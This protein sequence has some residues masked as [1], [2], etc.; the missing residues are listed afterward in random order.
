MTEQDTGYRRRAEDFKLHPED[1]DEIYPVAERRLSR[2]RRRAPGKSFL[3]KFR[4][5]I[6]GLSLVGAAAPL[7]QSGATQDTQPGPQQANAAAPTEAE[8]A[9]LAMAQ[10]KQVDVEDQLAEKVAAEHHEV[11]TASIVGTAVKKFDIDEKLAQDIYEIAQ[12]EGIEPKLAYG[13]VK[14]ESSFRNEAK[15]HVGALGLTQVM[16][17]TAKWLVPGTKP[18]DLHDQR[19]NLRLGFKYLN[20]MI[21][22]YDGNVRHALLAYNR[23]PGTVDR[24]LKRGGNPNNGYA[25]KVL[26]GWRSS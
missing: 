25:D 12:E 23:G 2:P 8:Q 9:R 26:G 5:P 19:T 3:R 4:Q 16:P 13:L 14:T 22:K 10:S 24:I 6:I 11:K 15:S 18:K 21:N 1:T 17:R 20:Q 7:I